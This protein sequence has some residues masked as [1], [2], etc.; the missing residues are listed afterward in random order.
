MDEGA[1]KRASQRLAFG[2]AGFLAALIIAV[3]LYAI[4]G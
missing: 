1:H 3:P 2:V 4:F